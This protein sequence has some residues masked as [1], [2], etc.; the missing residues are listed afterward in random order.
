M[1]DIFDDI[2]ADVNDVLIELAAEME[3]DVKDK[4]SVPVGYRI[5]PRGGTYIIRSKPGENPRK[6]T[7][8]LQNSIKGRV[9]T[10]GLQS[11]LVVNSDVFYAPI[12]QNK[13]ERL[14]LSDTA[15]IYDEV[16][17]DRVTAAISGNK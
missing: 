9:D 12:L 15:E 17:P 10:D 6:E 13:M 11:V 2:V 1:A 8:K 7:G 16:V 14:V 5:G 3:S 4:L